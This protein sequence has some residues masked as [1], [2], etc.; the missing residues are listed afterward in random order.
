MKSYISFLM[1][2]KRHDIGMMVLDTKG[3]ILSANAKFKTIYTMNEGSELSEHSRLFKAICVC[4]EK[5]Q[6]V[7]GLMID[8]HI[9]ETVSHFIVYAFPLLENEITSTMVILCDGYSLHRNYET[10]ISQDKLELIGNMAAVTADIILNP[11][12][13]IKGI[14]R[15]IEQ[16]LKTHTE[17]DIPLLHEKIEIYFQTAY[18]QV[19]IIDGHVKRFLLLGKPTEIPLTYIGVVPFLQQLMPQVQMR[20]L[21]KK[22]R[23][24]CEYPHMDGKILGHTIYFKE[25]LLALLENAFEATQQGEAVTIKVAI[26]EREVLFSIID[27]SFG[28]S[29]DMI[30]RMKA[31]F[32]TTKDKAMGLGLSFSE[33]IIHKM[34]GTMDIIA[35]GKGTKV[36]VAIP[37]LTGSSV[38]A[39][40]NNT[41]DAFSDS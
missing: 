36:E 4:Q 25:A 12:T 20:A 29:P 16:N 31:P 7:S 21:E 39:E 14:L 41:T 40:L 34:G 17:Q 10:R 38:R 9:G 35:L 27:Q 15:L 3:K 11:L 37:R 30:S 28:I 8:E 18:E 32:V 24:I 6:V 5:Q 22:V 33:L 2:S 26:T 1:K 19:G 23:M 13:V